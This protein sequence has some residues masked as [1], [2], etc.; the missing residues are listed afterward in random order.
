[1]LFFG[2]DAITSDHSRHIA[3]PARGAVHAWQVSWL[4]G[5]YLSRGQAI[6]A[7]VLADVTARQHVHEGH[8]VWGHVEGWA[9]ELGLTGP[10]ALARTTA[11]PWQA[12]AEKIPDHSADR[13]DPEAGG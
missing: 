3:Q 11:C 12:T 6:T 13:D 8:W 2:R 10:D 5:Q 4:P 9:A 1:M 7:M